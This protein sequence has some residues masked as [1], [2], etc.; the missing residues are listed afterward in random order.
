MAASQTTGVTTRQ[1]LKRRESLL[2]S[3][4]KDAATKNNPVVFA[5]RRSGGK[6]G[7]DYAKEHPLDEAGPDP[8]A[9]DV[10]SDFNCHT[11]P[12]QQG[13]VDTACKR[14]P[15][16]ETASKQKRALAD[17]NRNGGQIQR[18]ATRPTDN[19]KTD[20]PSKANATQ[21]SKPHRKFE[22]KEMLT[23]KQCFVAV[24]P[25][26]VSLLS[27]P[28]AASMISSGDSSKA[29]PK[30]PKGVE[31]IDAQLDRVAPC[32]YSKDVVQYWRKMEAGHAMVPEFIARSPEVT[33]RMRAVL[34]DWL[35]QVQ[36]HEDLLDETMHLC[37]VLIDRVLARGGVTMALL[38]LVGIT[39]LLIASKFCER[40]CTEIKTLCYLTDSTYSEDE[41]KHY[42]REVLY[43]LDWDIARPV[44]THFLERFLQ[45][46]QHSQKVRHMSMYL[47]DLGLTDTKLACVLPSKMAAAALLQA[48]RLLM[49]PGLDGPVLAV[50]RS[51]HAQDLA[52]FW[53]PGLQFYTG[54]ADS[55][56]RAEVE[57]LALLLI[58]APTS[59]FQG[60]RSKYKSK[61]KC[62]VSI[63]PKIDPTSTMFY[64]SEDSTLV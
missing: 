41:V 44:C 61:E 1:M 30:M 12:L 8:L 38:Q 3:G 35:L 58:K 13:V 45:V 9:K 55:E 6:Q 43:V 20:A 52:S 49:S 40:F 46:H 11:F 39:C 59:K 51:A 23:S 32:I 24:S 19:I 50:G 2:A 36:A 14:Q 10:I 42:E 28:S 47:L 29:L 60:A 27:P 17:R 53:S 5:G 56:L 15:K 21:P 54:Y 34:M 7:K 18:K 33:P 57:E 26:E 62:F 4:N 16:T 31:D 22:S 64:D 37:R 48:R 25:M 63:N